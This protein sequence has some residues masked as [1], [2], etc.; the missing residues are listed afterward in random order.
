[1]EKCEEKFEFASALT[2]EPTHSG[3]LSGWFDLA[4]FHCAHCT[5]QQHQ[6]QQQLVL[7][8]TTTAA[9]FCHAYPI[10]T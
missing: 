8:V 7:S 10:H 4:E 9:I 6:E 1:M 2:H 3:E 5:Q